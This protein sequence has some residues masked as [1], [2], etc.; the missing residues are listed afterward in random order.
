MKKAEAK[1]L[2]HRF[3]FKLFRNKSRLKKG[4]NSNHNDS[5]HLV[6][7]LPPPPRRQ[8]TSATSTN[9]IDKPSPAS[10]ST[11]ITFAI[12]PDLVKQVVADLVRLYFH[13]VI[14]Q[15]EEIKSE[16]RVQR[17]KQVYLDYNTRKIFQK[18]LYFN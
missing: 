18:T 5:E 11:S 17:Q 4:K 3:F 14:K 8:L 9:R 2:H 10:S 6:P 16:L 12:L 1:S 13:S 7:L 15:L